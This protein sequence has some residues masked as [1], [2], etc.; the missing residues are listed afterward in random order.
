L[1]QLIPLAQQRVL[2]PTTANKNHRFSTTVCQLPA[3]VSPHVRLI[4]ERACEPTAINRSW[5]SQ[6]A[7]RFFCAD[8][9][10]AQCPDS[11]VLC[12]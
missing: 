2:I 8:R 9:K 10:Q 6:A 4:I 7:L 1:K 12:I 5:L 3:A 11:E